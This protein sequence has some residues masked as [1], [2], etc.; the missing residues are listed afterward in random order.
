MYFDDAGRM[1]TFAAERYG[2]FDGKYAMRTWTTPT[3]EYQRL[4]G[5]NLP[6]A[7]MGVWQLPSGDFPYIDVRVREILYNQPIEP[8]WD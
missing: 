6:V 4:G 8:F 2:E 1:L 5:L 3:T 7:G